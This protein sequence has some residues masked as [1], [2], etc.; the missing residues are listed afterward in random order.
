MAFCHPCKAN[1]DRRAG[2]P[3]INVTECLCLPGYYGLSGPGHECQP[4]LF[5]GT[6]PGGVR[7]P[8]PAEGFWGDRDCEVFGGGKRCEE[9]HFIECEENNCLGGEDFECYPGRKGRL[10]QEPEPGWF[11]IGGTFF[12]ECGSYG[13]LIT[14]VAICLVVACWFGIEMVVGAKFEVVSVML[15]FIQLSSIIGEYRSVSSPAV[16]SLCVSISNGRT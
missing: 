5:G 13:R 16:L 6:C 14:V 12:L 7:V 1:S 9:W 10:C 4:C 11:V 15:L 3:G 2:S 8:Y